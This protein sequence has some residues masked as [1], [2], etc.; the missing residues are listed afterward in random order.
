MKKVEAQTVG[1]L[2]RGE[3]TATMVYLSRE[4]V[5][6]IMGALSIAG[7]HMRN[8]GQ[9]DRGFRGLFVQFADELGLS[10]K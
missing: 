4:D 10:T 1:T 5:S 7:A 3:L 8:T 6:L 2:A 9:S